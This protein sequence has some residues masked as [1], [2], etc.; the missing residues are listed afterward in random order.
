MFE[1]ATRR[2][3]LGG[4]PFAS[5]GAL[6]QGPGDGVD[7]DGHLVPGPA[8][9]C[10]PDD[11]L[12]QT[13]T[14]LPVTSDAE[15]GPPGPVTPLLWVGSRPARAGH[16]V[17]PSPAAAGDPGVSLDSLTPRDAVGGARGADARG[18]RPGP[19]R[20]QAR[21]PAGRGSNRARADVPPRF[22]FA[23]LCG[24]H[25]ACTADRTALRA[26]REGAAAA[27][28]LAASARANASPMQYGRARANASPMLYG[29]PAER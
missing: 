14:E 25:G 17:S 12:T 28:A 11:T 16:T 8:P 29:F 13:W 26:V 10:G 9:S 18:A 24:P 22:L 3:H 5:L 1:D 15:S 4:N 2:L 20:T 6:R 23:N 7:H 21:P 19:L 27:W